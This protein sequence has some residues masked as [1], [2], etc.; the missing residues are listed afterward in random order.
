MRTNTFNASV[1]DLSLWIPGLLFFYF[2]GRILNSHSPTIKKLTLPAL[3]EVFFVCV[4]RLSSRTFPVLLRWNE[5]LQFQADYDSHASRED[6][7]GGKSSLHDTSGNHPCRL[8]AQLPPE[9]VGEGEARFGRFVQL[10]LQVIS[11]NKPCLQLEVREMNK[12]W[13][14]HKGAPLTRFLPAHSLVSR[15][16]LMKVGWH[17]GEG[18][19]VTVRQSQLNRLRKI[20]LGE[21][22]P[23]YIPL[24]FRPRSSPETLQQWGHKRTRQLKGSVW[25]GS[26]LPDV[27]PSDNFLIFDWARWA[28]WQRRRKTQPSSA[29]GDIWECF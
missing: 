25:K 2:V 7:L 9:Q 13:N 21:W 28:R 6:F 26:R 24:Q 20:C 8:K 4:M 29:S 10:K 19:G 11:P 1:F 5:M 22:D 27:A 23:F 15:D 3:N 12:S 17:L 18:G 16:I 14:G